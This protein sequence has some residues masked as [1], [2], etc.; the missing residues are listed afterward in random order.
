MATV[1]LSL[2]TEKSAAVPAG[3]SRLDR[4]LEQAGEVLAWEAAAVV[5]FLVAVGPIALLAV[6]A[7]LGLRVARRRAD[8]RLL[9][10]A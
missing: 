7:W 10:R 1:T 6:L 5:L 9:E 3:K 8:D 2:T 4:A